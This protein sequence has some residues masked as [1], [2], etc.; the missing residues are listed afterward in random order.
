MRL[1]RLD[2]LVAYLYVR[3][4]L[5]S[6]A[7]NP[8]F[9]QQLHEFYDN[10]YVAP[11]FE[12]DVTMAALE[13]AAA[14]ECIIF[15]NAKNAGKA[16]D[17]VEQQ[18]GDPEA[19]GLSPLEP[20]QVNELGLLGSALAVTKGAPLVLPPRLINAVFHVFTA[21]PPQACFPL[22]DLVSRDPIGVGFG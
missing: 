20:G 6:A 1:R 13:H 21:W 7:I 3:Q 11:A 5:P 2:H 4:R 8:G 12:L 9:M 22:L 16:A 18:N 17:K 15:R 19:G 14:D 10:A